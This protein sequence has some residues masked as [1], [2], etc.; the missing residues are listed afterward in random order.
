[1]TDTNSFVTNIDLSSPEWSSLLPENLTPF[2]ME[3]TLRVCSEYEDGVFPSAMKSTDDKQVTRI[4]RF[5]NY[6]EFSK[7]TSDELVPV[8]GQLYLTT[9]FFD[10]RKLGWASDSILSKVTD[11][12]EVMGYC[13]NGNV[14]CAAD[15]KTAYSIFYQVV[16]KSLIVKNPAF[17][18]LLSILKDGFCVKFSNA[19]QEFMEQLKTL[20]L[21]SAS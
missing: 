14:Y 10:R 20:L 8:D 12:N 3:E 13:I 5:P 17:D 21:S 7:I 1:M 16:Y 18:R 6:I 11:D 15:K 4:Q 2:K 9:K 19:D